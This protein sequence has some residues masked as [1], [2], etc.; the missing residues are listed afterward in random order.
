MTQFGSD[1]VRPHNLSSVVFIPSAEDGAS[2]ARWFRCDAVVRPIETQLER[3][4]T[5][6]L[7]NALST[8][9]LPASLREC[10]RDLTG[11]TDSGNEG[12][13]SCDQPHRAESLV[14]FQ[15]NDPKVGPL[16]GDEKALV[17]YVLQTYSQ[18]CADRAAARV[19]LSSDALFDRGDIKVLARMPNL[20]AWPA[21]PRFHVVKCIAVASETTVGTMEGL[22][23]KPFA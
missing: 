1:A 15:I 2:G 19:G 18:Q 4:T 12:Y 7:R 13:I 23:S 14:Q 9:P 20:D 5:E 17:D 22:G 6:S 16:L 21:D 8:D 3:S 11:P 10:Y